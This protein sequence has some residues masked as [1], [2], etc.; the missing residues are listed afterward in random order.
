M[1]A[2]DEILG[3]AEQIFIDIQ[4]NKH[5]L[6][7]EGWEISQ[8]N[9]ANKTMTI[10]IPTDFDTI[11][12]KSKEKEIPFAKWIYLLLLSMLKDL[13]SFIKIPVPKQKEDDV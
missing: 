10:L 2:S 5:I 9:T 8:I 4:N 3:I 12:T 7:P 11:D 13:K 6:L 1:K